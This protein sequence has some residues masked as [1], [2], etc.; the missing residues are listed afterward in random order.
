MSQKELIQLHIIQCTVERK[1][2]VR[3]AADRLTLP[4]RRIKQP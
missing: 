2:T 3:Q 4:T 1:C